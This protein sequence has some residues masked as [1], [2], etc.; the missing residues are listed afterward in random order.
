MRKSSLETGVS[1]ER[2]KASSAENL[3]FPLRQA[4]LVV[5]GVSTPRA[6][7]KRV[8]RSL[9]KTYVFRHAKRLS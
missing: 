3:R 1:V 7:A 6:K 5:A 2:K 4:L 9:G 8:R